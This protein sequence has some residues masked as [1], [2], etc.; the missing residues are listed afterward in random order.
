VIATIP[1]TPVN[2]R[3][4][5]PTRTRGRL[6]FLPRMMF[7]RQVPLHHDDLVLVTNIIPGQSGTYRYFPPQVANLLADS[8]LSGAR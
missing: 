8:G 6:R 7:T 5:T 4:A 2:D 1:D 3:S